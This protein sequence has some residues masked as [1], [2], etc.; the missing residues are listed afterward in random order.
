MTC[1]NVW[2]INFLDKFFLWGKGIWILTLHSRGCGV[3][4][5]GG[6]AWALTIYKPVFWRF[7]D[8]CLLNKGNALACIT[9]FDM[10]KNWG[11]DIIYRQGGPLAGPPP[12]KKKKK[13]K[14]TNIYIVG[15]VTKLKNHEFSGE[16][17]N[18][19]VSI[20]LV[21]WHCP[22]FLKLEYLYNF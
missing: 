21:L 12:Q 11:W 1:I 3:F 14:K 17:K 18:F 19:P 9:Q 4:L 15:G 22:F 20:N 10:M 2:Y 7:Y 5:K 8:T 6:S 16:R 13:K